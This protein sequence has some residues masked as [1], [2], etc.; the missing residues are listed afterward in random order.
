MAQ[1]RAVAVM[2]RLQAPRVNV[3]RKPFATHMIEDC[4]A[5]EALIRQRRGEAE[6]A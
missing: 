5:R 6:I 3:Q 4:V 1:L 2:Q